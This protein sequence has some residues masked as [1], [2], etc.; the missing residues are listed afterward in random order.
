MAGRGIAIILA[1]R[2]IGS[3]V[4]NLCQLDR[5]RVDPRRVSATV[6]DEYRMVGNRGIQFCA[7]Q[8]PSFGGLR[9]VVLEAQHPFARRR[10][11]RAFT[12]RFQDVGNGAQ[13]AIHHAE[14]RKARLRRMRVRI[15]EAGQY[16]L[17]AQVNF[18]RITCGKRQHFVIRSDRLEIF[19]RKSPR[20]ALAAGANS[21]SRNF[22]C[23]ESARV[24]YGHGERCRKRGP[25]PVHPYRK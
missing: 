7:R 12:Q 15:D 24:R 23:K 8:R 13:I 9:V 22:R 14:M 21:P 1:A 16:R 17:S 3:V 25:L 11:R 4:V 10:F 20:P 19:L 6:L 2:G 5:L 18:L